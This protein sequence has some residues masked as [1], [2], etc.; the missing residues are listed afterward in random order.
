MNDVGLDN[1][2]MHVLPKDSDGRFH[3]TKDYW[4]ERVAFP[5]AGQV[6]NAAKPPTEQLVVNFP[7]HKALPMPAPRGSVL[8][9]QPNCIHWGSSCSP[10]SFLEP[11]KSIAMSFRVSAEK[12][13]IAS[14]ERDLLSREQVRALSL[15]DRLVIVA[16]SMLMYAKWFPAFKGFDLSLLAGP[17]DEL[18]GHES[19]TSDV[20]HDPVAAPPSVGAVVASVDNVDAE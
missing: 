8:L 2:C 13:P 20:A 19:K 14:Y 15:E 17:D 18:A 1:G 6:N 4:H 9:W 7:M 12:R 16:E 10:S 5:G 11:R 3:L